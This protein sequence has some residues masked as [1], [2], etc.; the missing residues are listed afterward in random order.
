MLFLLFPWDSA[1]AHRKITL[2]TELMTTAF[3][4]QPLA[5]YGFKYNTWT[6]MADQIL[7]QNIKLN[8]LHQYSACHANIKSLHQINTKKAPQSF[9]IGLYKHIHG[10]ILVFR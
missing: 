3:L 10:F 6:I 4:E 8:A 9:K 1:A 2:I 5:L 7:T